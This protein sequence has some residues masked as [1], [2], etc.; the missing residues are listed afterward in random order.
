MAPFNR[1][2]HVCG[3]P[4]V[5]ACTTP[6]ARILP[7]NPPTGISVV[8]EFI[9]PETETELVAAIDAIAWQDSQSGRR[10][11]DFGPKVNFKKRK[12]RMGSFTGLPVFSR[13]LLANI[14]S[15][16]GLEDF[17][18]VEQCHLEYLSS[19]GAAI[20]PHLDDAW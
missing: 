18:A 11:Q 7:V 19:R 1:E 10:K 14:R 6:P 4:Q 15:V 12:V 17:E 13:Q 9:T 2:A 16:K 3:G 20:D 5:R 8:P